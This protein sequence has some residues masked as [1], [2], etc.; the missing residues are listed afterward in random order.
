M[1]VAY[2]N[3][4]TT[5]T[6]LDKSQ[7]RFAVASTTSINGLGSL[8]SPQSILVVDNEAMLVLNVPVA[9]IVEVTRGANGTAAKAH[10]T[11]SV[12][13]FG[14]KTLFGGLVDGQ[15]EL[16]GDAGVPAGVLP[17]YRLP[18][19]S[20]V[21]Y[22]GKTY[23]FCDFTGAVHS[24]VTVSIS[25]DGLFTSAALTTSHQGAVGVVAEGTSTSDQWGWV[26]VI[27]YASAQGAGGTSA[28]TSAYI[29]IVA[30]S[31]SSPAAGMEPI[32]GTTSTPQAI[33]Y[34]MF[35]VGA[36]TTAVTSAASHT[37]VAHPVYLNRPYTM[38]A[39]TDPGLS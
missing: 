8:T 12:V 27:G 31:V 37:G 33:I 4:T 34:G 3:S 19:G 18:L 15:V 9:G 38:L 20:E 30:G 5:S 22:A 16:V 39:V 24:G 35:I 26:Q 29:A 25:N 14:A 36:A 28:A 11:G 2:L 10:V 21:T 1:S 13:Y 32:I 7:T 6:A 23:V 17:A